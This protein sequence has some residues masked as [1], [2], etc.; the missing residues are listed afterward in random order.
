M[1]CTSFFRAIYINTAVSMRQERQEFLPE[2]VDKG[3]VVG[4]VIGS[5]GGEGSLIALRRSPH[6]RVRG[7]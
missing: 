7:D 5:R 1:N 6:R 2:G 3:T 4:S